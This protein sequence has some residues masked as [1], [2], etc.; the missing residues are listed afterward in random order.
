MMKSL[1]VGVVVIT[2]AVWTG[3]QAASFAVHL[4]TNHLDEDAAHVGAA[5]TF[6]WWM[7]PEST[8]TRQAA[9]RIRLV[10]CPPHG[11]AEAP[12][13]DS[14]AVEDAR[15]TGIRYAGPALAS[16]RRYGWRVAVRDESG[17]W[18]PDS[19]LMPF[20]TGLLNGTIRQICTDGQGHLY[21]AARGVINGS[22]ELIPATNDFTL[23]FW[24]GVPA[25]AQPVE[26]YLFSN[27]GIWDGRLNVMANLDNTTNT[28]CFFFGPQET[29]TYKIFSTNT[30]ADGEWH[31]VALTRANGAFSLWM[32]GAL[33]G[34]VACDETN[35]I[36][37]VLDWYI[38]SS[39]GESQGQTAQGA[40][41]D[42][43]RIYDGA[44]R[45]NQ[46]AELAASV[47]PGAAPTC[48]AA[49]SGA[50]AL[51][52]ALGT[53]VAHAYA[54]DAPIGPPSLLATP[55]GACYLAAS[56]G[57]RPCA[58]DQKTTVYKSTDGGATW[59]FLADV[60]L[61][62]G[63][64]FATDG[65]LGLLGN[66]RGSVA[67]VQ[68]SLSSDGDWPAGI[69]R[70]V[71]ADSEPV[72][73]G[74]R[75]VCALLNLTE[76]TNGTAVRARAGAVAAHRA[77]GKPLVYATPALPPG[78][79]FARMSFNNPD[80]TIF[81]KA[82]FG[83]DALRVFDYD[84][85]GQ[86]DIVIT[87]GWGT[88][89][90]AGTY[91]YRN[92]TPKGQKNPNPVFPKYERIDP[93]TL[94]PVST[95]GMFADGRPI[96][97]VHY[98]AVPES[99]EFWVG[100]KSQGGP[101]LLSDLDG[102]GVQ[103]LVIGA[104]D[105]NMSAWQDRYDARGN[106]KDIQLRGFV[107]WCHGL[108]EG[109]YG[110]PQMLYMENDLPVE[111]YG[112]VRILMEDYDHDGDLDLVLF[113]FM[114]TISYFE[115]VGTK[116]KPL[117]TAGRFLRAQDGTRLHGDLCLPYAISVD[118]DGDG[119]P[120]ILFGEEDSRVA[121]CR[122]TGALKNGLPVFEK[123]HYFLQKA[124]ELH[125]GALSC[126]WTTDWDGDGD[127]DI[128]CGNSHGQIAFI[129]N[130]SGPR[131][132]KPQWAPPAY[133]TEPDGKL[134]WPIAG[135]NG[136]IQGPCESKWGYA[137]LSVADWDGNGLP[138]IM[139]NNTMGEVMWWKNVGT[140][141][142]PKLDYAR[143][144]EVAWNGPQ[145]EL[146]WGWKKPKLQKNPQDLLTQWRTTPVMVDWNGDGLT[147]LV[148][149]DQDGYLAFFERARGAGGA[150]IVKHP[151]RAFLGMDGKPLRLQC[152]FNNFIGCGRR[153]FAVCDWDGDGRMDLVMNGGPN[154]EVMVQ[155]ASEN[156]T[157]TFKSIGPVARYQLSTH[158]PQPAA[159]DFDSNGVPDL[160]FGAMDGYLYYLRNPRAVKKDNAQ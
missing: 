43:L 137:T 99:K 48:P 109:K 44:L 69:V 63:A 81:L 133:L 146:A 25:A 89:P 138:D 159:C 128:I 149:L 97:D 15:S 154:V 148:M 115:N 8:G 117:F 140:R 13:W 96:G 1:T 78:M 131:V 23:A 76:A 143:R 66:V 108:G 5:P 88:W 107:Y 29:A 3:A 139:A 151:R 106:W 49:P 62:N 57:N 21:A 71:D 30:F 87:C 111:V 38:G 68:I 39:S 93:S 56:R 86:L 132:E 72:A 24:A 37:Q 22:R 144:V 54:C 34:S 61:G 145:P 141:T 35:R 31:H 135:K 105:R 64:L 153:K 147:D 36:G 94:P 51:P 12:V 102:D 134:I 77:L 116:T 19:R 65:S 75:S 16:G 58:H 70:A 50:T 125:F 100:R 95:G 11:A 118:W 59:A 92:P 28:L 82:G 83:I 41:M 27:Y 123:P 45:A 42:D 33:E 9:Y 73:T 90:W 101:R 142:K 113:D 10:Q 85:D 160:I 53:Q 158:D 26:Q 110:E 4:R 84:G 150:L 14:G 156:G 47:T 119:L 122:N 124:D 67:D 32:D 55:D 98:M 7:A 52:S 127:L 152:T 80:A 126:P 74:V 79:D 112:Q 17:V 155:T 104:S 136:S 40:F 60:A 121:W 46:I 18:G 157:W 103:D 20:T 130:L 91:L 2:T 114:D 120:D 129:E 6:S